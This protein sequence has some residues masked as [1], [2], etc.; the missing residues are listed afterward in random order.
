M[1]KTI[2]VLLLLFLF[3]PKTTYAAYCNSNTE[4]AQA[5]N[6][7]FVVNN[8]YY[9]HTSQGMCVAEDTIIYTRFRG[10]YLPTTYV[11]LDKNT[12]KE[13]AHQ[14]FNTLHSNSL[15][16]N[17]DT[18][19]V[20]SVSKNHAYVFSY[21]KHTLTLEHTFI[22]N[23]NC[24]KIAYVPSKKLYYLGTSNVIYSSKDCRSLTPV[25]SVPQIAINQG[26]GCDG[27]YLYII[28]YTVG[29]NY[30]YK[31]SLDGS[32]IE[33]YTL[34]S[35]TYR[36]IE[37]VDFFDDVM[38]LNIANSMEHNGL[39]TVNSKHNYGKWEQTIKPTCAK[40]G[41]KIKICKNS[42]IGA[43]AVIIRN[44]TEEGTYVGNPAE[45]I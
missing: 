23:H 29:K 20:V 9:G 25:F 2:F 15:T 40:T 11:I 30:L 31:Y 33:K 7:F 43:E 24:C 18:K 41:E 19:E 12:K 26:M 3:F 17:P 27:K 37:E 39:Y 4:L 14:E 5:M 21:K 1:R 22:L 34:F 45:K 42:T 38:I 36:E 44:I 6:P 8:D 35:D 13:I 10:D 32:L 16:Y 28:W